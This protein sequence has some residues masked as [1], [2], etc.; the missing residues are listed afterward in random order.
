[1]PNISIPITCQ[2]VHFT[3][4]CDLIKGAPMHSEIML[5]PKDL[6]TT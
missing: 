4:R 6:I 1:V 5:I 3:S 2:Q